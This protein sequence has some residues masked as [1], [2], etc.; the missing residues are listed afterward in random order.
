MPARRERAPVGRRWSPITRELLLAHTTPHSPQNVKRYSA[1]AIGWLV[2][3]KSASG[4][5]SDE[6]LPNSHHSRSPIVEERYAVRA[7]VSSVAF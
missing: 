7:N 6:K 3:E 1:S 2:M 5:P 4:A